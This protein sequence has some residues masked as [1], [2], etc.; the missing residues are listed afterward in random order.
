MAFYFLLLVAIRVLYL[1][2]ISLRPSRL[3]VSIAARFSCAAEAKYH[4]SNILWNILCMENANLLYNVRRMD[5]PSKIVAVCTLKE[6]SI[7][8]PQLI[9]SPTGRLIAFPFQ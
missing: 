9:N 6:W 2:S 8:F 3:V 7:D 4:C 5:T 1:F